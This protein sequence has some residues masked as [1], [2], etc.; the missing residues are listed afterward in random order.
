MNRMVSFKHYFLGGFHPYQS[1]QRHLEFEFH[2][3]RNRLFLNFACF[4]LFADI[5]LSNVL[6]HNMVVGFPRYPSFNVGKRKIM[7]FLSSDR[8]LKLSRY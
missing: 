1:G 8:L 4:L 2:G 6:A 3:H 5:S 7:A